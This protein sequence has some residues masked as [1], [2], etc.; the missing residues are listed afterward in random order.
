MDLHDIVKLPLAMAV[1]KWD[2]ETEFSADA[3]GL[4]CCQDLQSAERALAKLAGGLGED[5]IGRINTDEF[6]RQSDERD[7]GVY[8]EAGQWMFAMFNDHPYLAHRI[9]KMREYVTDERYTSLW[10]K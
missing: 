5:V 2:R 8:A 6:L 10:G 7:F 9:K 1:A 3:A 4:I